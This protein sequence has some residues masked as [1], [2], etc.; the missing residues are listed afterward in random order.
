MLAIFFHFS[1][2]GGKSFGLFKWE[3]TTCCCGCWW[4][5]FVCLFESKS[6]LSVFYHFILNYTWLL[7]QPLSSLPFFSVTSSSFVDFPLLLLLRSL[8]HSTARRPSRSLSFADLIFN[9]FWHTAFPNTV[10]DALIYFWVR[11]GTVSN[12][13]WHSHWIAN[14]RFVKKKIMWKMKKN[15]HG[16][17]GE[18]IDAYTPTEYT[19]VLDFITNGPKENSLDDSFFIHFYFG[20]FHSHQHHQ[21][22]VIRIRGKWERRRNRMS[23]NACVMCMCV[24]EIKVSLSWLCVLYNRVTLLIGAI[25][26][27]Y[28]QQLQA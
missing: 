4:K 19:L 26:Q 15:F 1:L 21:A 10:V 16:L 22:S 9:T 20:A 7:P 3:R 27:C 2:I 5:W 23:V 17:I 6:C 11:S 12:G 14:F 28:L 8:L 13:H 18:K 25:D 24:F